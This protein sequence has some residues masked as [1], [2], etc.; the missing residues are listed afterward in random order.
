MLMVVG[1]AACVMAA[2]GSTPTAAGSATPS[3]S[4]GGRGAFANGASGQLVQINSQTL[5]LTG[6]TGDT[7]VTYSANTPITK[8]SIAAL[9]DITV[10]TCVVATG[11]KDAAGAITVTAVRV[12]PKPAGGCAATF[13]PPGGTP[14]TPRPSFSPRPTPSGAA[15]RAAVSGEVTAASGTSITVLAAISGSVTITVPG[16]ATVT[17]SYAVT[18][19]A[20]QTGQCLRANGA[21]DSAGNV[22][23][24]S[25]TIT[26][27]GPS[28][29][30]TSGFGGGGGRRGGFPAPAGG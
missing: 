24:T 1:A 9:A 6:A 11:T 22:V 19:A 27:A 2:C 20:L 26:P 21:K 8:T 23:A 17:K 7:I 12:A 15:N 13:G 10:G 4:A 30:C 3:P 14:T 16:T 18:A 29:T 5:I 25:L 28:G